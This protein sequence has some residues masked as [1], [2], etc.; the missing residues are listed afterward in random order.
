MLPEADAA[1]RVRCGDWLTLPSAAR[2]HRKKE[3]RMNLRAGSPDRQAISGFMAFQGRKLL[4][5]RQPSISKRTAL[6]LGG[7]KLDRFDLDPLPL[8]ERFKKIDPQVSILLI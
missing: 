4:E 2:T 1:G 6:S 7:W 8:C 5:R 3:L